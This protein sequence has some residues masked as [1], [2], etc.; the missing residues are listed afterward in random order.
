[1]FESIKREKLSNISLEIIKLNLEI[2]RRWNWWHYDIKIFV[3]WIIAKITICERSTY[4]A[5]QIWSQ[6][7][8]ISY[9]WC[10]KIIEEKI[11]AIRR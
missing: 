5:T 3:W 7:G 8:G 9:Q 6:R 1:M 2:N 10:S 4:N 11:K